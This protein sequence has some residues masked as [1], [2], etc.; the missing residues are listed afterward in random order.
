MS[1]GP[2]RV[3][4]DPLCIGLKE[5]RHASALLPATPGPAHSPTSCLHRPT[6]TFPASPLLR[7]PWLPLF[8]PTS[9]CPPRSAITLLEYDWATSLDYGGIQTSEAEAGLSRAAKG[10]MLTPQ[11]LR[12]IVTLVNGEAPAAASPSASGTGVGS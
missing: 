8:F 9:L 10:G 1:H 11:Q 12:G 6:P 7:P 5:P 2:H 4:L 3:V